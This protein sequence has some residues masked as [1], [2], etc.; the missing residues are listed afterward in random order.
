MLLAAAV[1]GGAWALTD[2]P[3]PAQPVHATGRQAVV[4]SGGHVQATTTSTPPTA[5]TIIVV[6]GVPFHVP[7]PPLPPGVT[8]EPGPERGIQNIHVL[9]D[10]PLSPEA[11]AAVDSMLGRT[12][13][14]T[15]P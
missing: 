6:D 12:T 1:I 8:L 7:V 13:T 11:Q 15:R 4:G 3:E 2:D 14:T 5:T 9:V 10:G